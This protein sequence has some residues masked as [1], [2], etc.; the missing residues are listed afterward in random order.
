MK[1]FQKD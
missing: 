1:R